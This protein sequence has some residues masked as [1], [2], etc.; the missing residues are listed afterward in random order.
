MGGGSAETPS[1]I[2]FWILAEKGLANV[3]ERLGLQRYFDAGLCLDAGE[4]IGDDI[5]LNLRWDGIGAGWFRLQ[6]ATDDAS[7]LGTRRVSVIFEGGALPRPFEIL[8]RRM[9]ASLADAFIEDLLELASVG[10]EAPSEPHLPTTITG[11]DVDS[12]WRT[13]FCDHAVQRKFFESFQFT[14]PS[15]TI[16]HGDIEC[17]FITPRARL[18]LPRFFNYPFPLSGEAEMGGGFTDLED[19]DVIQGGQDKLGDTVRREAERMGDKGPLFVNTTC[20]PVIIGDDVD[21]VVSQCLPSCSHGLFHMSA[22]T[23]EPVDIFMTYLDK[24]RENV[25]ARGRMVMPGSVALVG[26]RRDRALEEL[27]AL[28][29]TLGIP[30]AGCILPQASEALLTDVL[31]AQVLVLRQSSMYDAL[32]ERVFKGIDATRL[33][34][35]IPWGMAATSTWLADI[36]E[37]VGVKHDVPSLVRDVFDRNPAPA[38][39]SDARLGFVVEPGQEMRLFEPDAGSG[40]PMLAVVRELGFPVRILLYGADRG[41]TRDSLDRIVT[42]GAGFIEPEV[43]VFTDSDELDRLLKAPDLAAVYSDYFYDKRL[44]RNGKSQFSAR[45][46]EPGLEGAFR[47]RARLSEVVALPFYR[48][49]AGNLGAPAADWWWK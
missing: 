49:Y 28:L 40:L 11:W 17:L 36:A 18:D 23:S 14:G 19:L 37:A 31:S 27:I 16:T 44:S 13:F 30:V 39:A 42:L 4:V 24:A 45:D 6:R 38:N 10:R 29:T 46:F 20:V 32:Y 5:R 34:L 41:R 1:D 15:T 35:P 47:T 33:T 7:R 9:V 8:M 21:L 43:L 2:R 12:G 22:R 48:R 26:F 3:R 25:L